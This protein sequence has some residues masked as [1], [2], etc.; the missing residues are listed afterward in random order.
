MSVNAWRL[1]LHCG[2]KQ[3]NMENGENCS[4]KSSIS[5]HSSQWNN[6]REK[7]NLQKPARESSLY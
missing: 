4:F 2:K 1:N 7:I 6:I 3:Y 5:F